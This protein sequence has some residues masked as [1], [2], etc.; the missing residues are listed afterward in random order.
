MPIKTRIIEGL[1]QVRQLFE[2]PDLPAE[3]P[4][5]DAVDGASGVD[6]AGAGMDAAAGTRTAEA[7]GTRSGGVAGMHGAAAHLGPYGPLVAAIREALERFVATD[8]RLHLSIAYQ[9]RYL[10]TAI[11]VRCADAGS[12]G[13]PQDPHVLLARFQQEFKPEQIKRFL[14][15]EVIAGLPNASAIDL[16]QF[17]GLDIAGPTSPAGRD[18]AQPY[19][20][21]LAALRDAPDAADA[22][23]FEVTL[24]GRW[25]EA[26]AAS[27][28]AEPASS[29][30][31]GAPALGQPAAGSA[32]MATPVA[33]RAVELRIEDAA[34]TRHAVLPS[35]IPGRR[36]SIGKDPGCDVVVDGTYASRRHCEIWLDD[37]RWWLGDTGSTNG[38]RVESDGRVLGRSGAQAD[39]SGADAR[40]GSGASAVLELPAAARIVLSARGQGAASAY[41]QLS[42]LQPATASLRTPLAP[43]METPRTPITP[44]ARP[45]QAKPALSLLA[46]TAEG[47]LRLT[48]EADRL[49]F[50]VG[51]SRSR[52]LV[53]PSA[54]AGVSG[55]HLDIVSIDAQGAVV[56]VHGDNGVILG[57]HRHGPGA[58]L[59]W[60][61]GQ[62]M[63]LGR[64]SAAE[65][66]LVLE[67]GPPR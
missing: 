31:A 39:A 6:G 62:T 4:S 45:A 24:A 61:S 17:A 44:I 35:V 10:L 51:R 8:L 41:P 57:S 30:T 63:E 66:P 50:S 67:L 60:A 9:D 1:N 25:Y 64:A 7:A 40:G 14:A 28:R 65:P 2:R 12:A 47:D 16:S 43:G 54:H 22:S 27:L 26:E 37:G 42:L 48:V 56:E 58:R 13:D 29:P 59:Q 19:A 5:A 3:P 38:T 52:S 20:E 53:V 55:H 23:A 32:G 33:G 49:P 18:E 34:G 21:L 15:R 36:Y 11:G 46:R